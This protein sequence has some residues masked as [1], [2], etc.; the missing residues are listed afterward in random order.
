MCCTQPANWHGRVVV[1][2]TSCIWYVSST[3]CYL[4]TELG[5]LNLSDSDQHVLKVYVDT[6]DD[7]GLAMRADGVSILQHV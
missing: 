2:S 4:G 1:R 3:C 5:Y 7:Y 6:V